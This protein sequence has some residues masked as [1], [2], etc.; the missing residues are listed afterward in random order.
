MKPKSYRKKASRRPDR[1]PKPDPLATLVVQNVLAQLPELLAVAVV[2]VATGTSLAVHTNSSAIDPGTAAAYNAEVVK[3]K[4][5][6]L[7]ALALQ[8]EAIEDILIT[9]SSQLHLLQLTDNGGRFIYLVVDSGS[10]SL[11]MAREVLRSQVGQL[12]PAV[13]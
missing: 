1:L 9:L 12:E 6:A 13:G 5:K 10:T 4:L 11:A 3:H 2:E 8:G 7:T